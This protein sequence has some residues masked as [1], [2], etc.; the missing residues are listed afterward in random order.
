MIYMGEI[1]EHFTPEDGQKLLRQCYRVLRP[2]G[3]IRIRVPDNARFWEN[4]LA[5][6][7]R[8]K[9]MPRSQWNLAHTRWIGMFF[10]DICTRRVLFKSIGHF[11]KWM[12]DEISLIKTLEDLGFQEVERNPFLVWKTCSHQGHCALEFL[13]E[14]LRGTLGPSSCSGDLPRRE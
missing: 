1:L 8:M 11:H 14:L 9:Q 4:Y 6:Y 13:S 5:E 7:R 3:V 12:Y 2:G 10:R